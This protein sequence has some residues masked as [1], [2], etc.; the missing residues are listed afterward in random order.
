MV[1]VNSFL[2]I[3]NLVLDGDYLNFYSEDNQLLYTYVLVDKAL[4][5]QY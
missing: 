4:T 3:F 2:I 5:E 1:L